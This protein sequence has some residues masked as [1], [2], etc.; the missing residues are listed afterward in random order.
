MLISFGLVVVTMIICKIP[1]RLNL[2]YLPLVLLVLFT[3]TFGVG[4]VFMHFGVFIEDLSNVVMVFLRLLFY[5][6][7]VFYSIQD[8]I[9]DKYPT[10]SSLLS[11]GNP[12]ALIIASLRDIM[13]YNRA[14]DV[15]ALCVWLALGFILSAIGVYTIYKYENSYTKVI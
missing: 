4:L 11:F 10:I 8:R 9:G 3:V 5:M 1:V 7:G 14:P 2:L 13:I 12:M 15:L 6:S